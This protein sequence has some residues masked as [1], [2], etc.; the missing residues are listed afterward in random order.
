MDNLLSEDYYKEL[1]AAPD[2][3]SAQ[4]A[5]M[6]DSEPLPGTHDYEM[7]QAGIDKESRRVVFSML[8]NGC[9]PEKISY[10][11]GYPRDF[12]EKMIRI[13]DADF[14]KITPAE[15]LT[16][17]RIEEEMRNGEYITADQIM[18]HLKQN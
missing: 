11:C 12:V 16:L 6:S 13:W 2:T 14:T 4:A 10:L 1:M 8:D 3:F 9:P 17:G 15:R 7:L 5:G 18:L